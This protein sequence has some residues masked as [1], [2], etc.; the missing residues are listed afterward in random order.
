MKSEKRGWTR[1]DSAG[2]A[3]AALAAFALTVQLILTALNPANL[4]GTLEVRLNNLFS[5]FT[6]LTNLAVALTLVLPIA[7]AGSRF[8][9]RLSRPAFLTGVAVAISLVSLTYELV[10]RRIWDPEGWYLIADTLFHDVVPLSFVGYWVLYVHKGSL[11]LR[12]VP[13]WLVYPAAYFVFV[14]LRGWMIGR[15]PYPFLDV[16]VLGYGRTFMNAAVFLLFVVLIGAVF[17]GVDR[18]MAAGGG[19]QRSRPETPG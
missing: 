6:I 19:R 11:S 9:A 12:Q 10:L 2:M 3:I 18:L 17:V 5:Y 4:P 13:G 7:A 16:T 14:L 15:Y 1:R 8:S